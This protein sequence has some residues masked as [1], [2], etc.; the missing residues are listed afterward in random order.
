LTY[1][2]AK[3]VGNAPGNLEVDDG[4][5]H[6]GVQDGSVRFRAQVLSQPF[7]VTPF[8]GVAFPLRSY[9]SSGHAAPG[10]GITEFQTGLGVG[11]HLDPLI[12]DAYFSSGF[13][14]GLNEKVDGRQ[15]WRTS[16]DAEVGYFIVPRLSVQAL[17]TALWTH[18]GLEWVSSDPN[19]PCGHCGGSINF[20]LG[21]ANARYTRIGGGFSWA[22]HGSMQFTLGA[23]TTVWGEN[24]DDANYFFSGIG[25]GFRT[26]FAAVRD[27]ME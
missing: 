25:Y 6:G 26:P 22:L 20:H 15:L 3:Y 14:Y 16:F 23:L 10:R 8:V 21:T 1:V 5:Y 19:V 2:A 13:T 7:V 11:R 9:A 12:S 27:E 17:G 18:G 24:V 4:D